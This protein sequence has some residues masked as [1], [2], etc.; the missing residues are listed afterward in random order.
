MVARELISGRELRLWRDELVS[1]RKAPFDTGPDALFVA[2]FDSAELGCFLELG[3]PLPDNVLDLYVEHRVETNGLRKPCGDGLVGALALRGLAHI[4]AEEKDAMRQLICQQTH[5]SDAEQHAILDYCGSD[6]EALAALL[7]K[8]APS[9]DWP[10]ALLRGRYMAAVAHMERNGVPLDRTV[11]SCLAENWDDL[12]LD[13]IKDVDADFGVHEGTTFKSDLFANWCSDHG[14]P[15]P[16]NE[17]GSMKLDDDTF[18]EQAKRWPVVQPLQELR[19]TLVA[20]GLR[21]WRLGLT[22]AT[23]VFSPLSNP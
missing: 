22:T 7:P 1:L 23:G 2:Y 14:I 11:L 18:R 19:A 13:L 12:K 9:I 10:R 16:R 8:M 21:G 3:W 4:D 15:W 17:S 6:V 20:F 5:W